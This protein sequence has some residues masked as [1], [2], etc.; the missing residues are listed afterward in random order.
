[1]KKPHIVVKGFIC[2]FKGRATRRKYQIKGPT[3][4]NR[5]KLRLKRVIKKVR[6]I[7]VLLKLKSW[8]RR[9]KRGIKADA[10]KSKCSW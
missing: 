1:V 4:R 2:R 8:T 7:H 9:C 6:K 5:E 10:H 3:H